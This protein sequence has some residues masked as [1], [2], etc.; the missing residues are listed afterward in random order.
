MVYISSN[1][2]RFVGLF[3][4]T[5]WELGHNISRIDLFTLPFTLVS[6]LGWF[7]IPGT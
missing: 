2:L 5:Y 4:M 3:R 7:M 6:D 1:V